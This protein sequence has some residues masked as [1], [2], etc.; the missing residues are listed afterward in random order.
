MGISEFQFRV[1]AFNVI[2][3]TNFQRPAAPSR[4]LRLVPRKQTWQRTSPDP[5]PLAKSAG[6]SLHEPCRPPP[7]CSSNLLVTSRRTKGP[8]ARVALSRHEARR[9]PSPSVSHIPIAPR[10]PERPDAQNPVEL[11]FVRC[12]SVAYSGGA[13]H[14][15]PAENR[16]RHTHNLELG[17]KESGAA[18]IGCIDPSRPLA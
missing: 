7:V 17:M 12:S 18:P 2:N 14:C 15:P 13:T 5:R 1:D 16:P 9:G 4:L 11:R 6:P 8:S 3:H 10:L